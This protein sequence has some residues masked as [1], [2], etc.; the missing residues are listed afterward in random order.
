MKGYIIP[1]LVCFII[2][3]LGWCLGFRD[4]RKYEQ[5]RQLDF[6]WLRFSAEKQAKVI[7]TVLAFLF[8]S[9]PV[10]A[11]NEKETVTDE[12]FRGFIVDSDS[13]QFN[14]MT[15]LS[16]TYYYEPKP[17]ITVEEL[18]QLLPLLINK[19]YDPG[20]MYDALPDGAKRH[21]RKENCPEKKGN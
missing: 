14:S 10:F 16:C 9:L 15:L 12:D 2:V 7:I 17:D 18:S 5:K 4:G 8:L 1:V 20:P 13:L 3:F 11:A 19:P 6:L 21:I